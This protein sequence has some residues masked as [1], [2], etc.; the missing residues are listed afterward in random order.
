MQDKTAYDFW[1]AVTFLSFLAEQELFQLQ[2][3]KSFGEKKTQLLNPNTKSKTKSL[4][5]V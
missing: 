4:G 3:K 2:L 5:A 1:R